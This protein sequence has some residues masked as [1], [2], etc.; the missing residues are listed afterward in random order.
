[1]GNDY[2][3]GRRVSTREDCASRA[4]P[5]NVPARLAARPRRCSRPAI[6][7]LTAWNRACRLRRGREMQCG[8][9][10]TAHP[11]QRLPCTHRLA[12]LNQHR[13]HASGDSGMQ[14]LRAH[15]LNGVRRRFPG[16]ARTART[17][18]QRE[19]QRRRCGPNASGRSRPKLRSHTAANTLRRARSRERNMRNASAPAGITANSASHFDAML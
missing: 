18:W 9:P 17:G 4:M 19:M 2:S 7:E 5:L 13:I 3:V 1:M 14:G 6:R 16:R 8:G 12:L 10:G 11:Q 15:G